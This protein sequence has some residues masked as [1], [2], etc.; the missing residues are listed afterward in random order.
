ML[1]SSIISGHYLY[2][3]IAVLPC[4]LMPKIDLDS[5]GYNSQYALIHQSVG[6]VV[7]VKL[8]LLQLIVYDLPSTSQHSW[9]LV[10]GVSIRAG[11]LGALSR[12]LLYLA[13]RSRKYAINRRTF[14]NFSQP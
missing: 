4:I 7:A 8:A 14:E 2:T 12:K 3:P 1:T 5:T 9:S 6:A 13:C 10:S 11:Y